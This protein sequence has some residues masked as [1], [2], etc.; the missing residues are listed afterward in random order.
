[1]CLPRI[2][3]PLPAVGDGTYHPA[4]IRH[5]GNCAAHR[6]LLSVVAAVVLGQSCVLIMQCDDVAGW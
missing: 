4:V 5:V 1:V 3:K 2:T 6:L